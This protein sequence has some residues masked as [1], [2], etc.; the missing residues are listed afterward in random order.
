MSY[1]PKVVPLDNPAIRVLDACDP[2]RGI[3]ISHLDKSPI[4][5]KIIAFTSPLLLYTVLTAITLWRASKSFSVIVAILLNDFYVAQPKYTIQ[6]GTMKWIW[7]FVVT[8]IDY[9][10]IRYI[11]W[12]LITKFAT[13]HLYLR[14]RHGFR[15]TEVVFRAPTGRRYDQIMSLPPDQ[16]KHA[17]DQALIQATN[18][19][20]LRSNTGFN[21]RSPPWNLCYLA[22]AHAYQLEAEGVYDLKNWEISVWHKNS[23][24]R[25]TLWEAWKLGDSAQQAKTLEVIKRRLKDQGKLEFLAK[26]DAIMAQYK[27][28][29]EEGKAALTQGLTDLFTQEGLDLTVL[30][31]EAL[32]EMGETP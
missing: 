21:T 9:H 17:W 18:K 27:N 20:F 14:L 19:H 29:N 6:E 7:K 4:K 32:A 12:P 31:D 30:W 10:L 5:H 23:D 25:W 8:G 28:E 11:L 13:T 26:W 16:C 24:Q 1:S 22:S 3:L 15:Q 2:G